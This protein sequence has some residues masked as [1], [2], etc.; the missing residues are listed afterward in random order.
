MRVFWR[1]YW[2]WKLLVAGLLYLLLVIMASIAMSLSGPYKHSLFD[3]IV[4][5][6]G[7]GSAGATVLLYGTLPIITLVFPL[8][9]DRMETVI[10]VTRLKQ[11]KQLF[12][13][14]VI[15]AVCFNFL[16][17]CL[18]AVAGLS[19]AYF[20]TGSLDNL[21]GEESGA[22]YYFLDNKAHFP[23]YVPHVTGWKVWFYIW[24]NRFFY[25]MMVSMFVLCFQTVFQKKTL[26]FIGMMILFGTPFPY[27]LDF[28]V[29]LHPIHIEM[30]LWLSWQDQMFNLVYLLFWN[31]VAYFLASRLYTKKEFF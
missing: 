9:I 19:A 2:S 16:L 23:F 30:P 17:I 13:Q 29:F 25:L 5:L 22:I 4:N 26:T 28:S 7:G 1:G 14:H 15:F 27:L 12:S 10:V 6:R 24:S 11:Q 3:F 31:A 20:L 8:M 21:W 18:M